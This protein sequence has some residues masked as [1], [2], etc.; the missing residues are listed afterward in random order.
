MFGCAV[1]VFALTLHHTALIARSAE[2]NF[3]VF[4]LTLHHAALIL[5]ARRQFL[6][7]LH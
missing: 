5:R 6:P 1:A 7:F 4:A 3:T 2:K